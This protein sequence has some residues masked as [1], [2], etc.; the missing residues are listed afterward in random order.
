MR[1]SKDATEWNP[2]LRTIELHRFFLLEILSHAV[3][4]QAGL[5]LP[6]FCVI[7]CEFFYC[8]MWGFIDSKATIHNHI[9][10]LG[11]QSLTKSLQARR[12]FSPS[13]QQKY[14]IC[15]VNVKN[16]YAWIIS[17][18]DSRP[19][20]LFGVAHAASS[21]YICSNYA[22]CV[23]IDLLRLSL[24]FQGT[25]WTY[26]VSAWQIRLLVW[27]TIYS[28]SFFLRQILV[29]KREVQLRWGW[30]HAAESSILS[31][32]IFCGD[33]FPNTSIIWWNT[34]YSPQWKS[35]N[36]NSCIKPRILALK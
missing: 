14:E 6:N 28:I 24:N 36:T 16:G 7:W 3:P 29:F 25:K 1:S 17:K 30:M 18:M 9:T 20:W 31:H 23:I 4:S 22:C 15:W 27:I 35:Y 2:A 10:L 33:E 8:F 5:V 21:G 34:P 19:S 32:K 11:D 26:F 12:A 13:L